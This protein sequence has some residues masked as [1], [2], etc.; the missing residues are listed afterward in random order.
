M[1]ILQEIKDEIASVQREPSSRDL[2]ILA[3]IFLVIPGAIGAYSV[4]LKHSSTGYVWIAAGTVLCLARL[5]PPLFKAMY[6]LWIGLS[7]VL[8]YFVS[9]ILLTLIFFLIITPLGLVMRIVG[10]DPMDRKWDPEATSYWI[11]REQEPDTS[12]ERYGKQF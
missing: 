8:G 12:I 6:R 1:N 9:R 4:F 3:L 2:T 5:I 10:R 7:V 11:E